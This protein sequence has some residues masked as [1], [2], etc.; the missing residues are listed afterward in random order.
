MGWQLRHL[1]RIMHGESFAR[2]VVHAPVTIEEEDDSRKNKDA[3]D[4]ANGTANEI[5]VAVA[6]V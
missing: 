2:S 4:T 5:V 3:N 6:A 1:Y